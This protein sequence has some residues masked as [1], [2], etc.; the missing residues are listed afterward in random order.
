MSVSLPWESM[1]QQHL[2]LPR[3]PGLE[4]LSKQGLDGEGVWGVQWGW[5]ITGATAVRGSGPCSESV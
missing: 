4:V 1:G 2:R 3:K 5:W